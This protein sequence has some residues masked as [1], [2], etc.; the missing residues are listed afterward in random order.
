AGPKRKSEKKRHQKQQRLFHGKS[1]LSWKQP[2][3]LYFRDPFP[4]RMAI[5]FITIIT[6]VDSEAK[7][8]L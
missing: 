2:S 6:Q 1:F 5:N 8:I 3:E 4:F 7:E